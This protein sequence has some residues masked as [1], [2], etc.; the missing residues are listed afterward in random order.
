MGLNVSNEQPTTC[1]NA[2]LREQQQRSC[3]GLA[4][5]P[6]V[7]PEV[8]TIDAVLMMHAHVL[9]THCVTQS[10]SIRA[11]RQPLCGCRLC[12]PQH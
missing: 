5:S 8:S 7:S 2:L 4:S 11:A 6:S 3:P 1:I 12:W 9:P 10:L